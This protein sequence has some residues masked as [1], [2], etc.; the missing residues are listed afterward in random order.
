MSYLQKLEKIK[1]TSN[2]HEQ[3][4]NNRQGSDHWVK[5]TRSMAAIICILQT[6]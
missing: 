6:G 4:K 2:L 5:I 3:Q 1:F